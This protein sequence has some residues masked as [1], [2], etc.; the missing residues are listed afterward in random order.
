MA[1]T[2]EESLLRDDTYCGVK[3][4]HNKGI[5][6]KNIHV[7]NCEDLSYHWQVS[8]RRVR[9]VYFMRLSLAVN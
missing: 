7:W 6:G 1:M 8:T 2:I 3:E 9:V 4:W 5:T